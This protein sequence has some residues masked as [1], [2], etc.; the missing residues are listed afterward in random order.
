MIEFVI[1]CSGEL[2]EARTL[3]DALEYFTRFSYTEQ[4]LSE[5]LTLEEYRQRPELFSHLSANL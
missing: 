4:E 1:P 5:V 3:K 2:C